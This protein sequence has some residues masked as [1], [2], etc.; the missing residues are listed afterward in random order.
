MEDADCSTI[1]MLVVPLV[2]ED[3]WICLGSGLMVA[4]VTDGILGEGPRVPGPLRG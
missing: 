1:S 2:G 4:S 3:L